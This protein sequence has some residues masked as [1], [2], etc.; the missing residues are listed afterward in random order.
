MEEV[1]GYLNNA[2]S[3]PQPKAPFLKTQLPDKLILLVRQAWIIFCVTYAFK[4]QLYDVG[5]KY[6][7]QRGWLKML[8]DDDLWQWQ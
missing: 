5:Q 7:R 8:E 4:G 6:L 3:S 1:F 2:K